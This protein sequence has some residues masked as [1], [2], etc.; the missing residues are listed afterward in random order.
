MNAVSVSSVLAVCLQSFAFQFSAY[1]TI[2]PKL[3]VSQD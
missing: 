1:Q 3:L 2:S